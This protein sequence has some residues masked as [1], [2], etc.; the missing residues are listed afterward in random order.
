MTGLERIRKVH[1]IDYPFKVDND[2]M[3]PTF[4]IKRN[5]AKKVFQKELDEMY[6]VPLDA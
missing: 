3:T 2:L 4:K 1:V 5:I 6:S